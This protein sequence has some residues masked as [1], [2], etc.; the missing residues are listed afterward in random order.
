MD[1]GEKKPNSRNLDIENDIYIL[2]KHIM[3]CYHENIKVT[4]MLKVLC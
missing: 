4:L 1:G 2:K 3:F